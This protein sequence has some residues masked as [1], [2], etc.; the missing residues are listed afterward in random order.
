MK[1]YLSN[2]LRE[3]QELEDCIEAVVKA[4]FIMT[5]IR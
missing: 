3:L 2:F 5:N 4:K 1:A